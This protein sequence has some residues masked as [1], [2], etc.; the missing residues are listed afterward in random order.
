MDVVSA[1]A[2]AD[3]PHTVGAPDAK[4][5]ELNPQQDDEL[6]RRLAALRS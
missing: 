6:T 5:G 2:Q 4:V 3:V 1:F